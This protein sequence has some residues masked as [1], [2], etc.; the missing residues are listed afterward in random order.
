MQDLFLQ[1]LRTWRDELVWRALQFLVGLGIGTVLLGILW[2]L[3]FTLQ[4]LGWPPP[5]A[6]P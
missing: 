4:Q 6:G 2:L 1:R 5:P 3:L